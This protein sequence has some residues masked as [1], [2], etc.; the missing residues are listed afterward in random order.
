MNTQTPTGRILVSVFVLLLGLANLQCSEDSGTNAGTGD[1]PPDL[2]PQSSFLIDFSAFPQGGQVA[3]KAAMSETTEAAANW[4][5]AV[6]NVIAWNTLITVSLAIPVASYIEAFK[7]EPVQQ[8]DGSWVWSYSFTVGVQHTAEL[9]AV[10]DSEGI[11]WDMYV[12]KAGEYTDFHW[13]SGHSNLFTTD[14]FWILYLNPAETYEALRID[15]DIDA[16]TAT[17][18]T[19]YTNI[20]PDNPENGGYINYGVT[21]DEPLEA[22]YEIYNK[23]ADNLTTIQWD[24]ATKEG[25]VM[26]VNHFGDGD[27]HCWDT[28]LQDIECP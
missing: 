20:I 15:W 22:F 9:H 25:R 14:G 10:T 21:T 1:T 7:H 16:D 12:T 28:S 19:K 23:G 26:D 3:G 18:N 2:P 11:Q 27:W 13:Y 6:G 17:A 24:R 8:N 5:F 4:L